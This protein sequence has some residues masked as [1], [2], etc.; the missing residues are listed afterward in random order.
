[1]PD[2]GGGRRY[3]WERHTDGDGHWKGNDRPAGEDLA[4]LRR[5]LGREA[6]EVPQMW[7]FYRT[8]NEQGWVT[9]GLSA[10]HVALSLFAVHQ[11]GKDQ[12][13]HRA[14]VGL[15]TAMRALRRSDKYS[16]EAVDRRFSAAATATS[17]AELTGHLRGLIT[18]LRAVSRDGGEHVLDYTRLTRDLRDWQRPDRVAA[19]RRRWGSQYFAPPR[20]HS[21]AGVTAADVT[22][23]S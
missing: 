23:S 7:P 16:P 11:Q 10:E 14:D 9:Q 13:V 8:L 5:G 20:E 6:G 22:P 1:M 15:G 4:A 18:Q 19:V 12:P 17:L 3:Y 2:A 21:T